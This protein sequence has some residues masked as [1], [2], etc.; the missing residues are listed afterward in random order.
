MEAACKREVEIAFVKAEKHFG[1]T[2]KRVP[3]T[4]SKRMT[5]SGGVA[6]EEKNEETGKWEGKEIRLSAVLLA[7]NG[8]NFIKS[9]PG[10]E[11][12]HIITTEIFGG[13]DK[14][15]GPRWQQVMRILGL[16]PKTTHDYKVVDKPKRAFEYRDNDGIVRTLTIIRHNK[17][18]RG[19]VQWYRWDDTGAYVRKNDFIRERKV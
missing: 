14:P 12:A 15:H 4:F 2:I 18:Q 19:K 8:A 16:E 5:H 11:A 17:L 10:H 7:A 1:R 3:V 6:Y 13:N 9:T